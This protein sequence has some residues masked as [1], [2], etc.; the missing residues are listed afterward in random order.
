MDY[1]FLETIGKL[2]NDKPGFISDVKDIMKHM[3]SEDDT[4]QS[5]Q[6]DMEFYMSEGFDEASRVIT[7]NSKEFNNLAK[8]KEQFGK[9]GV[10]KIG[11]E[12]IAL[13]DNDKSFQTHLTEDEILEY[14][15][16]NIIKE[17]AVYKL[18][19][20]GVL[21]K[22]EFDAAMKFAKTTDSYEEFQDK[23]P[24]MKTTAMVM[25][26]DLFEDL[27]ETKMYNLKLEGKFTDKGKGT[28]PIEYTE[29]E[30]DAIISFIKDGDK[31]VKIEKIEVK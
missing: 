22:E 30:I 18:V 27:N 20:T 31:K 13:Y 16:S 28:K 8:L 10:I 11:K 21:S 6:S 19:K 24:N 26:R 3:I 15:K 5:I 4:F 17:K 7:K 29:D 1:N 12:V 25:F 9:N 2:D 14:V 23:F